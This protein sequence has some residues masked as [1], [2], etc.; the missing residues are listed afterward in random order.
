MPQA[1]ITLNLLCNS[2]INPKLS[3]CAFFFGNQASWA[4]HEK[5][6]WTIGP[7]L[8]H[9]RC[10]KTYIPQTRVEIDCDTLAFSPHT[11]SIPKVSTKDYLRQA[12]SDIVQ[13]LTNSIDHLPYLNAGDKT[14]NALLQISQLLTHSIDNIINIEPPQ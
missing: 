9:Y 14:Q 7:A 6:G 5:N 2:Q 8:N 1:V 11:I 4:F 12:A 13:L 10:I 3:S